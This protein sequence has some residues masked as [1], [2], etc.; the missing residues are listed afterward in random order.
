MNRAPRVRVRALFALVVIAGALGA[1]EIAGRFAYAWLDRSREGTLRLSPFLK[2]YERPDP[3][4][5]GNWVLKPDLAL[6]LADVRAL[7]RAEGLVLAEQALEAGA[8]AQGVA[9]DAVIFRTNAEGYKGPPLDRSGARPRVLAIGDSCTFG[10]LF[11]YST[12]PRSAERELA[13]L[14]VPAEVVNA[15]VNGYTPANALARLDEF[16]ALDPRVAVV[17]IGWNALYG[18]LDVAREPFAIERLVRTIAARI[19]LYGRSPQE[20]ALEAYQRPKRVDAS[21]AM[22][23]RV[24]EHTPAFL[25]DVET[26]ARGLAD[27]GAKV[28][29]ATLPGLYERDAAPSERAL[30]IGHLPQFTTNPLVVAALADGWNAG[31]RELA[32]RVGAA[33][34]DLDAWS[35]TAFQPRDAWFVDSVHLTEQG[36]V[37]VGEQIA[38][39]I[40]PL[41]AG[42]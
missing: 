25:G 37:L 28:V 1:A 7:V 16:R 32:P 11:E 26:L 10:S 42:R 22:L 15:G 18:D 39:A 19:E 17:Y 34:V 27:G 31:L 24:D 21:D 36:Q 20:V 41:L 23:A 40:A 13:A 30:A 38:R 4:H 29:L 35:R 2:P 5:A 12:W 3:L 8:Q 6:T 9:D 33:L 14:G